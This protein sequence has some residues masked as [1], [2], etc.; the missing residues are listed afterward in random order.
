MSN[1]LGLITAASLN[2]SAQF[3]LDE[4][5]LTAQQY[6]STIASSEDFI[7]K[8]AIA[9]GGSFDAVKAEDLRQEWL[10]GN[11]D[12]LPAIE[13][14]SAAE[15]N[16]A[17]G[18]FSADTNKIYLSQEYITQNNSNPQAIASVLLEELGHFVDSKI[19]MADSPGDEGAIFSALV[20]GE[21]LSLSVLQQLKAEDDT[22]TFLLNEQTLQVEQSHTV[23]N[24]DVLLWP[25]AEWSINT[26]TYNFMPAVPEIYKAT[27]TGI[28][29]AA[30]PLGWSVLAVEV[31]DNALFKPFDSVQQTGAERALG[32]WAEVADINFVRQED[33]ALELSDIVNL[34]P[35]EFA[36]DSLGYW[37]DFTD[38][39]NNE[40]SSLI[41]F[42]IV[43]GANIRFGSFYNS[44]PNQSAL[45]IPPFAPQVTAVDQIKQK[46]GGWID[47]F[48]DNIPDPG[49]LLDDIV[50]GIE[51]INLSD[52]KLYP[53]GDIWFNNNNPYLFDPEKYD[54]TEGGYAFDTLVHEIGHA[55]GLK[56]PNNKDAG[57]FPVPPPYFPDQ[58]AD[59]AS[60]RYTVM[61]YE[62][63]KDDVTGN[64]ILTLPRTPMLYDIAASQSL[65]GA[66]L[67]TRTENN[68][69]SW[70]P[71]DHVMMTIWDA[72]GNDTIDVSNQYIGAVIDL[73]PG[74]FSSIGEY[75]IE[76][77]N[78]SQVV[79]ASR[80]IAIAFGVTIEN[81]TGGSG[82]DI[83]IGNQVN[84]VLKGGAGDDIINPGLGS[85]DFVDGEAG[86]DLLKLDYSVEDTGEGVTSYIYNYS[87]G[88]SGSFSRYQANNSSPL[89]SVSFNGIERFQVTGSSKNDDLKGGMNNDLLI[90][91]A[92]HD[93]LYG[94][95]GN[96]TIDGGEGNDAVSV[97][98]YGDTGKADNLDGGAGIDTLSVD[99]SNQTAAITFDSTNPV[100]EITFA[101]ATK[102]ANF[103][104][105]KDIKTGSGN[106]RLVQ[107]G[108][109]DNQLYAGSGD[110]II[111]PGLGTYD[112]VDGE[113][114]ND[115]LKLDYSVE[116]T[117]QGVT[118]YINNYSNGASGSFS[119]YQANNSSPLDSVS[120]NGIE[121][122]QVTGSSKND[123]L[124]GGM[125]NDLLIGGAGDDTLTGGGGAD[126][127]KAGL[128]D[129]TYVLNAQTAAGS[130]IQDTGG[131][132]I[133]NFTGITLSL[134]APSAGLAGF[135]RDDTTLMIDLNKDGVVNATND[136]A[137]LDFFGST[138]TGTGFI[139]TVGNLSGISIFN[140]WWW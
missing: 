131:T 69:Y 100:A 120:F 109:M 57:G 29:G 43:N 9:F 74:H 6:L 97:Y 78:A 32:L 86:N 84:N 104:I 38:A 99:L 95:Q 96:D 15:I 118:S 113:A 139:E 59:E 48:I 73:N 138:G 115:L 62:Q 10:L 77:R 102:V 37:D 5:T 135:Q 25:G 98:W 44:A 60:T 19:N 45:A 54:Y 17:N 105:F 122:F 106:D 111:N 23:P 46:I 121:R 79:K 125:N 137:I 82:D 91:G 72:G 101:D 76:A 112:F 128:G 103:E 67:N 12:S 127:L 24:I 53:F 58:E 3:N 40:I 22:A 50:P 117:G 126:I 65:Y 8:F 26:I 124:K 107:L 92:D 85:Y 42:P 110:D 27:A 49:N 1:N 130:Q 94:D 90:G 55:L 116:D 39:L 129:N 31:I 52:V 75:K 18:A 63:P 80:N 140:L 36:L 21:T 136:L 66:N 16:G 108:R 70:L 93:T 83:L 68:I 30:I 47:D 2:E 4:A 20:R 88:A 64:T 134:A 35:I 56:H 28:L 123:D 71:S 7:T 114:G 81:A 41:G 13:I 51:L 61:S 34:G 89:D 87:N 132:D 33:A 14:R 11:F 119:R 133:L